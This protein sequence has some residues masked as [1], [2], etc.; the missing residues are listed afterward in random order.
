[1]NEQKRKNVSKRAL[2]APLLSF[3]IDEEIDKL[4][5][6]TDWK[7]GHK[8]AITLQ[9]SASLR[10]VLISMHKGATLKEHKVEGPITLFILSGNIIFSA[11][12]EKIN[13]SKNELVV[14]DKTIPH[15]LEALEDS[16]FVL[17][18]VQP[19]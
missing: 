8:D 11:A 12:D 3:Q 1:M 17:T 14:L 13:V 16:T 19:K 18:I 5:K 7:E 6:E 2:Q 10:V 15:D 9:K 4:K